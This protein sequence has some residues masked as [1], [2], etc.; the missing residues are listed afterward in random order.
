MMASPGSAAAWGA[1]FGLLNGGL[2]R[3]AL[4]KTLNK[5]DK[6]FYGVFAAGL[7]WRLIFLVTAVWFLRG[8]KYIILLPFAG[9]L[10]FTQFIF[11]VVPLKN[12][13]DG[14]KDHT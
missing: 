11:E 5:P 3:F 12:T 2:S 13:K 8:K 7:F 9:A 1:A 4:Q 6:V 14:F 10:I